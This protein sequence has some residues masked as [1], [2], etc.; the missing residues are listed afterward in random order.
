ME[1]NDDGRYVLHSDHAAEL[2]RVEKLLDAARDAARVAIDQMDVWQRACAAASVMHTK[3]L[4]DNALLRAECEAWR[5]WFDAE[6]SI[7][8]DEPLLYQ[9]AVNARA[10]TDAA[11]ILK[12]GDS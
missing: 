2:A 8:L 9:A 3:T 11:G 4:A 12:G 10:A 5:K 7:E 1:E 6:S